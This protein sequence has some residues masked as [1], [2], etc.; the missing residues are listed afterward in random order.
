M[1]LH[2]QVTTNRTRT[3][4]PLSYSDGMQYSLSELRGDGRRADA[5]LARDYK[6]PQEFLAWADPASG[7]NPAVARPG[8]APRTTA[9]RRSTTAAAAS[10]AEDG[11]TGVRLRPTTTDPLRRR[12][13]RGRRRPHELPRGDRPHVGRLLGGVLRQGDA[14][15]DHL[16]RDQRLDADSDGDGVLDGADDQDHDDVPNVMELSRSLAGNVA[17]QDRC[18]NTP[19]NEAVGPATTWVNPFNP[20]SPDRYSRTCSRHPQIGAGYPPFQ[21]QWKKLRSWARPLSEGPLV[22]ALFVSSLTSSCGPRASD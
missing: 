8:P 21:Q 7:Y 13:R 17:V 3:L 16:R 5:A 10:E 1:G 4:E 15:P 2:L 12:A 20:C 19:Q 11:G 18:G 22:R 14:V 6:A 9:S